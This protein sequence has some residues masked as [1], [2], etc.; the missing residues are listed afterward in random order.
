MEKKET[1]KKPEGRRLSKFNKKVII[2]VV[3]GIV[4]A[5][6]IGAIVY[7]NATKDNKK[8]PASTTPVETTTVAPETVS[9]AELENMKKVV[10]DPNFYDGITINGVSV[11]GKSKEEVK[12]QFAPD[13]SQL[14][15]V[16]F[17]V[18]DDLVPLKTD[19]LKLESNADEIIEEA[20]NYGRTSTLTGDQAIS[21][22]YNTINAL[23]SEPKN[24]ETSFTLGDVDVDTLVHQTLDECNTELS[25]ASVEGFDLEKLEFIIK[26]SSNG[27]TVDVDK[28]I[29]DVKTQF[30]NSNYQVVIPVDA[31]I[32]KPETSSDDLKEILGLVSSTTSETTDNDNRNTNIRL[33]C[34][35]LDGLVLQP[36]EKF[37]FNDFIGRRTS[38]GGFKMAHGIYNGS[39]R[40]EIG[41][42]ICQANTM[43]YQ[44]VTKANLKV[45][46]RKNHSIPSTYVD[47]GTDAT[48]TWYSP[49]FRFTNDSEYPIAI[50]AYYADQKVTVEIYGRKLPDGQHIELVGEQVRTISP[51]TSYVSDSSLPA[52]TQK[53]VS[54][55]RTGYVYKSYKVWYDKDGNEIKKEDYFPS[56]YPARSAIIHV[57]TGG[58][59]GTVDPNTGVVTPE[60]TPETTPDPNSGTDPV[61]P[62]PTNE[63]PAPTSSNETPPPETTPKENPPET[64]PKENPPAEKPAEGGG[65]GGG[66]EGG[67]GSGGGSEGGSGGGSGGEGGS[68]GGEGGS[69]A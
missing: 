21:D 13:A 5:G 20:Y 1:E 18:G 14:I 12:K 30:S 15:D 3:T 32:V 44:S 35:K 51:G 54:S 10:D 57:G 16:K 66:S 26:E 56:T 40:D 19:G 8:A 58:G 25:E 53:K 45:D 43:L 49:N 39:M 55:G 61:T 24:Y 62:P 63:T 22:R 46:E 50:H 37:N 6:S 28:A 60:T 47:K 36:G 67:S 41:G 2:G 4:A 33:V 42:G 64:T 11:A 27:C 38:E 7:M 68:G 65:S 59:G 9:P 29:A 31:E 69:G 52:G 23:K 17:K 34:E 48:V